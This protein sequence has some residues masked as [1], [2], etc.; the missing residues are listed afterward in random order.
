M[1]VDTS[2]LDFFLSFGTFSSA[3]LDDAPRILNNLV[4]SPPL[5]CKASIGLDCH[6]IHQRCV[7]IITCYSSIRRSVGQYWGL[8]QCFI[9]WS[10]SGSPARLYLR[11]EI[12]IYINVKLRLVI[13]TTRHLNGMTQSAGVLNVSV[14]ITV[15]SGNYLQSHR[16]ISN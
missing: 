10:R 9:N 1:S 16:I 8:L 5:Q 11:D 4:F 7:I 14:S 2:R 6:L 13:K 3:G 12:F 15:Q